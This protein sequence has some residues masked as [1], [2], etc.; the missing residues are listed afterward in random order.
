MNEIFSQPLLEPDHNGSE[1]KTWGVLEATARKL[2]LQV[3]AATVEVVVDLGR[4]TGEG[5]GFFVSD[6]GL[7]ATDAHV[8]AGAHSV[9]I[10]DANRET[11]E[12][13]QVG[14]DALHDLALF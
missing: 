5:S 11:L 12:V 8:T 7:I 3:A 2:Y 10:I 6:D 13:T 14:V 1:D 9:K 4:T